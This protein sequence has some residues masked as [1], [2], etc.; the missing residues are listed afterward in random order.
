MYH[1]LK[2][3]IVK[4]KG[5]RLEDMMVMTTRRKRRMKTM[6]MTMILSKCLVLCQTQVLPS[7]T[8]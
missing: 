5:L 4:E 1:Q 3:I 7:V 2:R 8:Q 6:T